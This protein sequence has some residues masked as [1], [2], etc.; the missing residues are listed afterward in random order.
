MDTVTYKAYDNDTSI[1]FSRYIGIFTINGS[2]LKTH[3]KKLAQIA[4]GVFNK[5]N[6]KYVGHV[7]ATNESAFLELLEEI[8]STSEESAKKSH[9][10]AV[11]NAAKK[12]M[13]ACDHADLGSMGY[14]HGHRV[15]CPHCGSR[16]T[17]W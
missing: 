7:L 16:A 13:N 4:S 9:D 5:E 11:E 15:T 8:N 14:T 17:V 2:V 6:G 12:R 10:K 3:F 1:K